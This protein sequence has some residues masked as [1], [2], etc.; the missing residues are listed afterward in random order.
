[1]YVQVEEGC[2]INTDEIVRNLQALY[3]RLDE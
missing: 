2:E 3:Q 1:M